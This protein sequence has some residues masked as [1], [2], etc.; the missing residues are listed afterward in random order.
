LPD[1]PDITKSKELEMTSV[2]AG[3]SFERSPSNG[4]IP[5]PYPVLEGCGKDIPDEE[6]V[7]RILSGDEDA[8]QCL[9]E[10]Y[11]RPIFGAVCRIVP[12][13]EEARD[14][15]Q[16]I[17]ITIYRSLAI[18]SPQRG[19]LLPWIYRIATNRAI[20]CR[21]LQRRRAEL[22]WTE[23]LWTQSAG[24]W[25]C[26]QKARPIERTLEYKERAAEVRLLLEELPQQQK[27]FFILRYFDG[28]KLRE[29]AEKEGYKL[30]TV[31]SSLHRA[32]KVIQRRLRQ[33]GI[34]L[35]SIFA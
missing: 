23:E 28:M 17:F 8:F 19:A 9:Y 7:E 31:K 10:K 25:L 27:R 13:P 29:I 24:T 2:S 35:E 1:L 4:R 21:R 12:D 11:R 5:A 16:E 3:P 33:M 34:H 18:W 15:T 14:A 26:R 6:L 30:G 20:D 32:T 22:Q